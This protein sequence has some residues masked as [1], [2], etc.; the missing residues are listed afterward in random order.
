MHKVVVPKHSGIHRFACTSIRVFCERSH[1]AD[2]LTSSG[3]SLYRALL[4]QCVPSIRNTPWR[5]ETEILIKQ[6]FRRYNALQSPTQI[7]NAL[8]GGYEALDL[9]DSA[10]KGH[11]QDADQLRAILAKAKS[12]KEERAA[13]ERDIALSIPQRPISPRQMCKRESVRF[14]LETSRR[15][16][17]AQS[18]LLRPRQFVNGKRKTPVLV[19]ARGVPFLRFKKPQPRNLSGVLRT[20]LEKRW[21]RIVVRE[22]LSADLLF[23]QDEDAWDHITGVT[24][25]NSWS[26]EVKSSLDNVCAKIR[27]TD[28]QNRS[29]AERMW[30]VVLDERA[31]ANKEEKERKEQ[32]SSLD[33]T[34]AG[35]H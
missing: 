23:A 29:L 25:D 14:Q 18:V 28:Q 12:L 11:Q 20:M 33:P 4:R 17:D 32:Q 8:K 16:P 31:L 24:E 2:I 19:N 10:S 34:V 26:E 22:R 1:E 7:T 30:Q 13:R 6:R 3:L 35:Q 9:L 5:T 27:Q 15:H 21:H